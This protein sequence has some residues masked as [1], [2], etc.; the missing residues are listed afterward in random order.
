[1]V[2]PIYYDRDGEKHHG[3]HGA[4]H[5]DQSDA[6]ALSPELPDHAAYFTRRTDTPSILSRVHHV[7]YC[8]ASGLICQLGSGRRRIANGPSRFIS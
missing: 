5:P 8:D 7:T 4:A 2:S 1:M 6:A 3:R